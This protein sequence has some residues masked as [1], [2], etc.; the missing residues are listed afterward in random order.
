MYTVFLICA[1]VGGTVL[2]CQFIMTLVGLGDSGVDLVDDLPDSSDIQAGEMLDVGDGDGGEMAHHGSNWMFG[3][4]SFRTLV[5]AA[6]FFGLGG[7]A[8]LHGEQPVALQLVIATACGGAAML[9]VHWLMTT[10]YRLGQSGNLRIG[11]TIGKTA[12][13]YIP[14]PSNRTGLGKVQMQI[15]GRIEEFAAT[16]TAAETLVTGAKVTVVGVVDGSTL[17]V[18]PVRE[19]TAT[20]A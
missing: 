19:P 10:F 20:S 11:G 2:V 9:L 13:V 16:T 14:I 15:Q 18:E 6:T 8:A 4:V 3:I 1:V 5:A 12:T 7:M 17:E